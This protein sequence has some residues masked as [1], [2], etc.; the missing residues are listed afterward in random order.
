MRNKCV[1]LEN[2]TYTRRRDG[3]FIKCIDF[4]FT[5]Y[6]CCISERNTFIAHFIFHIY[7]VFPSVRF[8]FAKPAKPIGWTFQGT[9]TYSLL[10][11]QSF[12]IAP[13][14]GFHWYQ[15]MC[16]SNA[17]SQFLIAEL[18]IHGHV[19]IR[20]SEAPSLGVLPE[21]SLGLLR[22]LLEASNQLGWPALQKQFAHSEIPNKCKM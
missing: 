18:L 14:V 8:L 5:L 9:T 6:I 22:P 17:Y 13:M 16:D 2:A 11:Y 7:S 20:P 19:S 21:A 15:A 3:I 4:T 12:N 10:F 1:S